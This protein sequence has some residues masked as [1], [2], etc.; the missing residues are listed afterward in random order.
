MTY[1][2]REARSK[3]SYLLCSVLCL[4]TSQ[5]TRYDRVTHSFKL[6]LTVTRPFLTAYRAGAAFH[7][8]DR[9][10]VIMLLR[11][12]MKSSYVARAIREWFMMAA[13]KVYTSTDTYP[14]SDSSSESES[15]GVVD[16]SSQA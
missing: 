6:N 3:P 15:T 12:G 1:H 9:S 5:L 2:I 14:E 7:T 4:Q 16:V 8:V 11:M 13:Q 10:C